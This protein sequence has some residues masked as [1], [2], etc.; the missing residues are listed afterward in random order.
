MAGA[1]PAVPRLGKYIVEGHERLRLPRLIA[2]RFD[3]ADD[4]AVEAGRG[5]ASGPRSVN[6]LA[7]GVLARPHPAGEELVHDDDRRGL[8]PVVLVED[9]P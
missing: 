3:D 8:V 7:D 1:V 2:Y 6:A 9:A 5:R 4:L